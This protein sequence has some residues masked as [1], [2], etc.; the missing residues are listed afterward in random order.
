MYRRFIAALLAFTAATVFA[1]QMQPLPN[2]ACDVLLPY[3]RPLHATIES[4]PVCRHAYVLEYSLHHKTPLWVAHLLRPE[5]TVG[6]LARDDTFEADLS[7]PRA[8]RVSPSDFRSSGYDMGHMVSSADMSWDELVM[9][10]SFIMTNIA[11]QLPGF[12]RGIW[13]RLEDQTRA[14]AQERKH[15]LLVYTGPIYSGMYT[16]A[17]ERDKMILIPDEYFKVIVDTETREV[18]AFR[19]PHKPSSDSL[20]TFLTDTAKISAV[21]GLKIPLPQGHISSSRL[22]PS[23][24]KSTRLAKSIICATGILE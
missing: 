3:G 8:H 2:A 9:R 10:E 5:Y 6:C 19:I 7:I 24:L 1:Q 22:W 4:I 11:P 14:W 15:P 13:R 20:S 18:L 16:A 17:I 12:N 21:T 23:K